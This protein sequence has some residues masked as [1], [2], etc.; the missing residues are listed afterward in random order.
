MGIPRNF[1]IINGTS[2]KINGNIKLIIGDIIFT[3]DNACKNNDDLKLYLL[4]FD[5]HYS[6][7]LE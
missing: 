2:K 7:T 4:C 5:V 6:R 3:T 1:K